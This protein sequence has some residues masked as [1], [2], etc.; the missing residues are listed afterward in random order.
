MD[1]LTPGTGSRS[2]WLPRVTLSFHTAHIE[3]LV[4]KYLLG[5]MGLFSSTAEFNIKVCEN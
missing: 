3:I 2:C 5:K 1:V 4:N